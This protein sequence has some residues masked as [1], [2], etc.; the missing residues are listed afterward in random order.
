MKKK[1]EMIDADTVVSDA[2]A[3]VNLVVVMMMM[4]VM[5]DVAEGDLEI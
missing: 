5:T 3:V 2:V 4:M 1:K